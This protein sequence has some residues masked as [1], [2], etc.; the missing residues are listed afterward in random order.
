MWKR[1]YYSDISYDVTSSLSENI[2]FVVIYHFTWFS[3]QV[4]LGRIK[5][6]KKKNN[7]KTE[8]QQNFISIDLLEAH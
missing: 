7:F 3:G 4:T 5:L 2:Y 1:V 8:R 6:T